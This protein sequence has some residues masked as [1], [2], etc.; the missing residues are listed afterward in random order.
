MRCIGYCEIEGGA[1]VEIYYEGNCVA[2][3]CADFFFQH[4]V[5]LCT[6]TYEQSFGRLRDRW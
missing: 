6:Q 5:E 1:F 3:V 4:K 2:C